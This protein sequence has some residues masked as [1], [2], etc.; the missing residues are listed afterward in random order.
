M[1]GAL[2]I[3]YH[4]L[5]FAALAVQ[6]GEPKLEPNA[7]VSFEF[8]A[9]RDTLMTMS[10]GEKQPPRLSAELPENYSR[11]GKFP[12]FIFLTGGG[13]GRGDS[14]PS[15]RELVGAHDFICVNL[16]Q[17]KRYLNTNEPFRG[18]VISPEDFDAVSRAYRTMLQKLFDTVPNITAKRSTL[19]G[20]SNG[21]NTTAVLLAGQDEFILKHFD[22]FFLIEG[23]FGPLTANILQKPSMKRCRFLVLRGDAPE[24]E[25]PG[26]RES[27][28]YLAR[29]LESAA[30]EFQ[31][32][33]TS[34]LMQG[35]GHALPTKYGILLGKW[36]RGEKLPSS[37]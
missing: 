12:L 20:F 15:A 36:V 14:K 5:L 7:L 25:H 32:D 19:G 23:G 10:S 16:P 18:L 34:V 17:F 11:R 31:L 28:D 21:A 30:R 6:A 29:S 3:F 1:K 35:T 9:L 24:D 2:A 26:V 4:A 37:P 33:F 27:N 13:G 22:S 8:P